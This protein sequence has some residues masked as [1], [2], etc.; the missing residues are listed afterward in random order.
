MGLANAGGD[1]INAIKAASEFGLTKG[2][3]KMAGLLLYINDIHAIGLEAAAG[4]TLTEAFYWDMNDQTRAWSQR[5]YDKLK[6]MPNMSQAGTYS[7]VMHYLKAVQ[8]AG[9]DEPTA[10]MKQMKARPIN[11]FFASNGRIREDGRMVHDMYL[12]QVKKPSESKGAWDYYNL[13]GTIKGDD[14]FQSLALSQ[15]PGIKK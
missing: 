13:K 3:Q 10:V 2:G 14:A 11:D 5:Y 6:K 8:A 15:C 9:T 1:T 4:L 12:F 7:S